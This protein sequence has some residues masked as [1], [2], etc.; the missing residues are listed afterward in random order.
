MTV[1]VTVTVTGVRVRVRVRARLRKR[2]EEVGDTDLLLC[3]GAL[4]ELALHCLE[5]PLQLCHLQ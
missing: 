2:G 5:L 1:T 4:V 3:I